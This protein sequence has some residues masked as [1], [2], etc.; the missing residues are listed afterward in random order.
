MRLALVVLAAGM[1]SRYGGLKQL[2]PVG[3]SGELVLD[4]SVHDAVRAG[5]SR[6]VFVIRRDFA[7]EFERRVAARYRGSVEV[8]LAYQDLADLPPG[9]AVPEGRGKPWGTGHAIWSARELVD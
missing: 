3:P 9:F 5:F 7:G 4:Y 2:D 1:G 6:V 8:E